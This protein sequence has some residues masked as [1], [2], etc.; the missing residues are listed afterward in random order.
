MDR[1]AHV[2][3]D[4][5]PGEQP[6]LLKDHA[7]IDGRAPHNLVQ[8]AD[9]P[10]IIAVQPSDEFQQG[11]FPTPA[12]TDNRDQFGAVKAQVDV[13]QCLDVRVVRDKDYSDGLD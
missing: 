3:L 10:V 12:M 8:K 6:V 5:E 7:A 4:R 2:L 1:E 13:P 9:G 11:G